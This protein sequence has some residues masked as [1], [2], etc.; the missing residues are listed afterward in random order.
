MPAT[1]NEVGTD[2]HMVLCLAEDA[3]ADK[4]DAESP[5]E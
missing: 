4:G 1:P 2:Q 3:E 5:P